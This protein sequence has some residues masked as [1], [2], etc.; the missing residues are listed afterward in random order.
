MPLI[1]ILAVQLF[2]FQVDDNGA[3]YLSFGPE[4]SNHLASYS[5]H[6]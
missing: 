5:S 4:S 1:G 6:Q 3:A 2:L